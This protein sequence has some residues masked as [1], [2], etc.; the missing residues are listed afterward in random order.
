MS[1]VGLAEY[2][3]WVKG[4]EVLPVTDSVLTVT[5]P[6]VYKVNAGNS[7]CTTETESATIT[8]NTVD[9]FDIEVNGNTLFVMQG[10]SYQWYFEGDL[11]PGA[12]GPEYEATENGTYYVVIEDENGCEGTS[13]TIEFTINSTREAKFSEL[14]RIYP[15]PAEDI[16]ML[17]LK[18]PDAGWME[19]SVKTLE[20][21]TIQIFEKNVSGYQQIPLNLVSLPDGIYLLQIN[22]GKE[23][24]SKKFFRK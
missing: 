7:S 6:G 8:V 17:E 24:L 23:I 14:F 9:P 22:T 2:Y 11:V 1:V 18:T 10:I 21:K 5:E 15:N 16:L 12:N 19:V 13:N 4:E 3:I 20:G